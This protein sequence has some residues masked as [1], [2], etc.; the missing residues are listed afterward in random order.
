M[1]TALDPWN[2]QS[3]GVDK[4]AN[5]EDLHRGQ[6]SEETAS[7]SD[8]ACGEEDSA[9]WRRCSCGEGERG[10]LAGHRPRHR[11]RTEACCMWELYPGLLGRDL[12]KMCGGSEPVVA[13]RACC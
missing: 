13:G 6:G 8:A 2:E 1:L 3:H 4:E 11:V 9:A 12:P 10:G 7:G 5:A